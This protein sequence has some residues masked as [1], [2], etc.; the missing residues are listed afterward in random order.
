MAAPN[1]CATVNLY[2]QYNKINNIYLFSLQLFNKREFKKYLTS[3]E[4]VYFIENTIK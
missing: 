3:E 4:S 1:S 2:L